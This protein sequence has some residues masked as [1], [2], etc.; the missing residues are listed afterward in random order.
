MN[1]GASTACF[2]PL[3]TELSL[4]RVGKLG[5][6]TAELFMN[7]FSE[8]EDGFVSGLCNIKEEY[9]I[10]ICSMHPFASFAESYTLFSSYERRYHDSLELYKRFFEIMNRLGAGIFVV[11]GGKIPGSIDDELY[12]ERFGEFGRIGSSYGVIVAQENVVHYRSESPDFLK[13]MRA[14][15]GDEFKMVLDVKQ[16]LRAGYSPY[17]FTEPLHDS[18]VHIHVSDHDSEHDC[19]PPGEG[20]FDFGKLFGTMNSYGYRGE[21]IIELYSSGF[22]D[23]SQLIA[24]RDMLE[25]EFSRI[26]CK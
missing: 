12:F 23:D 4:E 22:T 16:A 11:H 9:G 20:V 6:K 1:I 18:I 24:S 10:N 8:M 3:E 7:S 13:R 14:Y 5:F 25:K 17:E 15:I 2:Y 19:T 26:S 21:Y